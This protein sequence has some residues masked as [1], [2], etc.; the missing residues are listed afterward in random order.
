L[1]IINGFSFFASAIAFRKV[2]LF[3]IILL[4]SILSG[5]IIG[6]SAGIAW[7]IAI[8]IL[9]IV[10]GVIAA[11]GIQSDN[12]QAIKFSFGRVLKRGNQS[13]YL[14]LSFI[15]AVLFFV[16]PL[17]LNGKLQIPKPVFN[18]LVAPIVERALQAQY[19]SDFRL[20]SKVSE[21]IS[22]EVNSQVDQELRAQLSEYYKTEA[23][24][25]AAVEDYKKT[26]AIQ[27]EIRGIKERGLCNL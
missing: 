6:T 4:G 12:E 13:W 2:F 18:S 21:F 19:S 1:F 26:P 20:S 10:F 23:A 17:G 14:V 11:F 27:A 22:D 7:P 5:L 16:S 8:S 15:V 24:L 3:I 25:A 9:F